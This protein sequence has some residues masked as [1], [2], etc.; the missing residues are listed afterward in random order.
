MQNAVTNRTMRPELN[1]LTWNVRGFKNPQKIRHLLAYLDRHKVDIAL[2]QETH[3]DPRTQC[4]VGTRWAETIISAPYSTYA[5]GVLI[6]IKKGTQF[7]VTETVIDKAGRYILL[8]G[9]LHGQRVGIINT[10]GPNIDDPE[11]FRSIWRLLQDIP[12]IALL[13]GGDFNLVLNELLDRSKNTHEP[14]KNAV[15]VLQDIIT[16]KQL[17]DIWRMRAPDGEEA[18]HH[19]YYHA[20]WSRIDFWLVTQE[21][22]Y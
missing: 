16:H 3:L 11:F 7:Q 15:K 13:W 1:L 14:H 22:A 18:T 10:Y 21:V 20:S 4:R 6:L 17:L 12:D 5:R 2:L 9:C 19:N 8:Q